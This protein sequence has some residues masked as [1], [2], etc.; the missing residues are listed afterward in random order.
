[1][2][3]CIPS[4][5]RAGMVSTIR[6]FE[7]IRG[8]EIVLFIEPQE[9]EAYKK[10]YPRVK[11]VDI[12]E[13]DKGIRYVRQFILDSMDEPFIM[14]D[15]DLKCIKKRDK[16][17]AEDFID[18]CQTKMN[19]IGQLGV[20]FAGSNWLYKKELKLF[21]RIWALTCLNPEIIRTKGI[22]YAGPDKGLFEDYEFTI[23]CALSGILTATTY[24]YKFETL[25]TM[26]ELKGG[27][28]TYRNEKSSLEAARNLKEKY[29]QFIDLTYNKLHKMVEVQVKWKKLR[30]FFKLKYG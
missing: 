27:C 1:M 7:K 6:V 23:S 2:K 29:P 3:V 9:I 30:K 19:L 11:I 24:D 22:N 18:Y 17:S 26:G 25:K 5:G 16:S 21:D 28:Q 15:D 4:K 14:S 10:E 13:N 20:S 8:A 12:K